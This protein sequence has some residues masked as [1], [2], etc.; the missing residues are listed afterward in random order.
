MRS[1]CA[2]CRC[3]V[4]QSRR[5]YD[6]RSR[7]DLQGLRYTRRRRAHAHAGYRRRHRPGARIGS[8]GARADRGGD[9]PRRYVRPRASAALAGLAAAGVDVIDI[10]MAATPMGYFAAHHLGCGS[11]VMHGQPQSAGLQR[12]EE[13]A[14]RSDAGGRRHPL[15]FE[16]GDL[17]QARRYS[18]ADVWKRISRASPPTCRADHEHRHRQ[19]R[20]RRPRR[21]VSPSPRLQRPR[22]ADCEVVGNFPNHHP[23]PVQVEN[24]QE[25]IA[26]VNHAELGSRLRWR[27][28]PPS[29]WSPSAATSSI[30]TGSEAASPT[31]CCAATPA[32]RSS[33]TSSARAGSPPGSASAAANR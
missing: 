31:T 1:R 15:D 29:A 33:T 5:A 12:P 30:P 18:M 27:R 22:C 21:R 26:A 28:R 23:D 13:G 17:A 10:G 2:K 32:R 11:V 16:S 14:G 20:C 8:A 6:V 19:R 7:R 3:P 24:L 4:Q 25:L 9:R